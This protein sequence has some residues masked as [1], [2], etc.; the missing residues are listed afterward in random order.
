MR[1]IDKYDVKV[2]FFVYIMYGTIIA[3]FCKENFMP[4]IIVDLF[5]FKIMKT[6][7]QKLKILEH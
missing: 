6:Y 3:S 4:T 1:K 2:T 7:I 5:F